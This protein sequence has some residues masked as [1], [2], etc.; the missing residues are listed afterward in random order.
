MRMT[1]RD[2][3]IYILTNDLLNEPVVKDNR[4]IGFYTAEEAAVN[5]GVGITTVKTWIE[6]GKMPGVKLGETYLIPRFGAVH[7]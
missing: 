6:L 7:A 2:L 1:G 4:I 5:M 3:I